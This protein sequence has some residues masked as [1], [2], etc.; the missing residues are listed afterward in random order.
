VKN[1]IIAVLAGLLAALLA[2]LAPVPAASFL[3]CGLIGLFVGILWPAILSLSPRG[4]GA[5]AAPRF[6]A[7]I[8]AGNIGCAAGPAVAGAAAQSLGSIRAGL[9]AGALF[10]AALACVL[11]ARLS[12]KPRFS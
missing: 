1:L 2:A 10:P 12:K 3:G 9:L 5:R 7:L 11:A 8:L 6:A 4:G